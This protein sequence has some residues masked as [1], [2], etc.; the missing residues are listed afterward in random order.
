MTTTMFGF[1]CSGK[2][3]TKTNVNTYSKMSKNGKYISYYRCYKCKS[4]KV[5]QLTYEESQ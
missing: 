3:K 1:F 4:I 5:R 2:C